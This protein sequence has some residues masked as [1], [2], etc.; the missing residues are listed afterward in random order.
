MERTMDLASIDHLLT[1]TRAVRRRLD[2]ARAV[3]PAIVLECIRLAMQAPI[4]A[5]RSGPEWIFVTDPEKRA[6]VAEIYRAQGE[7]LLREGV[8]SAEDGRTRRIFESALHLCDVLDRVPVLVIP[9]ARGRFD[10]SNNGDAASCYASVIPAAWSFLLALR[11]RGLGA[12]WTTLHL[13][14]EQDVA[15]VLDIPADVTQ[16][17]LFPVAYTTVNDFK[18]AIRSPVGDVTHWNAWGRRPPAVQHAVEGY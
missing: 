16:V 5:G 10:L 14:R 1:T 17:A 15:A 3:D 6:R 8:A 9:C 4:G 12:A 13:F 11:S 2:L 18:P 7:D